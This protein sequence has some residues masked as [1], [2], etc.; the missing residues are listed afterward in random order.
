MNEHVLTIITS[1]SQLYQFLLDNSLTGA[2]ANGY[3]IIDESAD[4]C[5]QICCLWK[6]DV[7]RIYDHENISQ[8]ALICE[9]QQQTKLIRNILLDVYYIDLEFLEEIS[10]LSLKHPNIPANESDSIIAKYRKKLV[11]FI[12]KLDNLKKSE[13]K[14]CS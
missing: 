13:G 4:F 10:H 8:R 12:A 2:S 5:Y 7:M 1:H 9:D 3:K 6:N 14:V 11:P